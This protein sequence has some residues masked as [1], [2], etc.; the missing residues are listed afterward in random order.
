MP[1]GVEQSD[2]EG[3]GGVRQG[4]DR[5][6]RGG[7]TESNAWTW[8]SGCDD[9]FARVPAMPDSCDSAP[10]M[11]TPTHTPY[12]G[13]SFE[14]QVVAAAA[15]AFPLILIAQAVV[16]V[17][18][19]GAGRTGSPPSEWVSIVAVPAGLLLAQ[20]TGLIAG[21][22]RRLPDTLDQS[23]RHHPV[24]GSVVA[25]FTVLAL[26]QTGRVSAFMIDASLTRDAS[27]PLPAGTTGHMCLAAYVQA[28]ELARAGDPNVYAERHYELFA[29]RELLSL[30]PP[31]EYASPGG[32][33]MHAHAVQIDND[34]ER[35]LFEALRC[36]CGCHHDRDNLLSTCA[37]PMAEAS[38]AA[39][40]Q[41]ILAG[42]TKADIL[43]SYER[44]HGASA[45]ATSTVAP[46]HVAHLADYL[47]DPYEYPPPFLMF[48]RVALALTND[49]LLIRSAWFILQALVIGG[50]S[51][52]VARWIGGREGL[53]AGLLLPAL[54]SSTSLL[55]NL[56]FGQIYF[57]AFALA[58]AGMVAFEYRR[59]A[60]GGSLLGAAIVMK[61]APALLLVYLLARGRYR[62]VLAFGAWII[63]YAVLGLVVLGPAPY[64]AFARY[65]LAR[66]TSGEAF[67]F[68]LGRPLLLLGNLSVCALPL[69]LRAFGVPGMTLGVSS[70]LMSIYGVLLL[71]VTFLASRRSSGSRIDQAQRWLAVLN[72]AALRSPLAPYLYVASGTIWLLTLLAPTSRGSRALAMLLVTWLYLSVVLFLSP[73]RSVLLDLTLAQVVVL[74]LNMW[75]ALRRAPEYENGEL[76]ALP[77]APACMVRQDP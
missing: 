40:R 51:L 17:A 55:V 25:L 29:A 14:R 65:Q 37:C 39:V 34:T 67:A 22:A 1:D 66:L 11:V 41:D 76:R 53:V 63:A 74:A 31:E 72:L 28:A 46:T 57:L 52:S 48:P 77:G 9:S 32:D 10:S 75:I 24:A 6:P 30:Q 2:L 43:I 12:V 4:A 56:E 45:L 58:I 54:W 33:A 47:S 16:L 61:V 49:F 68:F 27:T 69:K 19:Q 38:R 71:P 44:A 62:P 70:A 3:A 20:L 64:V 23:A 8:R 13:P 5:G 7:S 50:L 26:V 15:L 36:T 35:D 21:L 42:R 60:L 18:W 59:D 73:G